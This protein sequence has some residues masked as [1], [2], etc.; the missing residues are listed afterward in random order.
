MQ[1]WYK[2]RMKTLIWMIRYVV[3]VLKFVLTFPDREET[4]ASGQRMNR[5]RRFW[6]LREI[7]F[8]KVLPRVITFPRLFPLRTAVCGAFVITR[9]NRRGWRRQI[10]KL[11]TCWD[12][13]S[14]IISDY[15]PIWGGES[16][17][18]QSLGEG[19]VTQTF[20]RSKKKKTHTLR[21]QMHWFFRRALVECC[22]SVRRT[23][24]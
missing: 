8:S 12:A 16:T 10:S 1:I 17:C 18:V 23:W 11:T 6:S 14:T 7:W 13:T 19:T 3:D 21:G 5:E 9:E 22:K 24:S 2:Y 20:K 15:G 4:V